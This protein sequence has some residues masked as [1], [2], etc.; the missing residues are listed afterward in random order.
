MEENKEKNIIDWNMDF[1]VEQTFGAKLAT[2]I[3]AV[4]ILGVIGSVSVLTVH[5]LFTRFW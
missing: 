4:C 5:W 2:F 1:K 3:V